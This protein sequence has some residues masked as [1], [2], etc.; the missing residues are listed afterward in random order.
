MLFPRAFALS[1]V[2]WRY[3]DI[4]DFDDFVDR[5]IP[6]YELFKQNGI[7]IGPN[8]VQLDYNLTKINGE[9]YLEILKPNSVDCNVFYSTDGSIPLSKNE[10]YIQ[11]IKLTHDEIIR[12][13]AF[14][15]DLRISPVF[16]TK[17]NM[18][19]AVGKNV[20]LS[21]SADKKYNSGGAQALIN[22]VD[23]SDVRYKD[24]EWL[25]FLNSDFECEI[26]FEINNIF[27]Y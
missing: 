14:K 16:E 15:D 6:H 8:I 9:I 1:E 23:G 13:A 22:G 26:D 25:G 27:R 4:R 10:K 3:P 19:K 7:N 5:A 17:F 24:K 20:V 18:H 2:L 11:D 21:T 12:F